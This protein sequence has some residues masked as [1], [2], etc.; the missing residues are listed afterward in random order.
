MLN[1]LDPDALA[2][3]RAGTLLV[4][5]GYPEKWALENGV[6]YPPPSR[7]ATP[8][9]ARATA[10]PGSATDSAEDGAQPVGTAVARTC[11]DCADGSS[12][13]SAA[14][15]GTVADGGTGAESD[16]PTGV[17]PFGAVPLVRMRGTGA[18]NLV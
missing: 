12:A 17:P 15:D 10:S 8:S 11:M 1:R 2:A 14:S 18:E 16:A 9:Y 6:P 13:P 4:P 7:A 5:G 3:V